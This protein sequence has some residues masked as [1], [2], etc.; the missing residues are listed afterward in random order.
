MVF[1][2]NRE[3]NAARVLATQAARKNVEIEGD[4]G[5]GL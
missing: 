2:K 3:G 4:R 1:Y 5:Y